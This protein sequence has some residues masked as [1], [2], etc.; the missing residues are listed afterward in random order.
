MAAFCSMSPF[1]V[2]AAADIEVLTPDVC[3]PGKVELRIINC[4]SCSTFEWQIGAGATFKAGTDNYATIITDTG[5]YDVTVKIKTTGGITFVIGKKRAFF[6]RMSP[7]PKLNISDSLICKLKDTVVFTDLTPGIVS[8]DWLI[9]GTVFYLAPKSIKYKFNGVQGFKSVYLLVRDSWGC[10]GTILKDSAVAIFD[11]T[12]VQITPSKSTGCAP[13]YVDFTTAFDTGFQKIKSVKWTFSGATPDSSKLRQPKGIYYPKGDTF[14]VQLQLRTQVGCKYNYKFNNVVSLGDTAILKISVPKTKF[15]VNE[16][17]FVTLSGSK[18]SN[19]NWNIGPA[20]N[21]IDTPAGAKI[22]V[23]FIDT[24]YAKIFVSENDRG[25]ISYTST[26]TNLQAQ[27]P[28]AYF[29][30][31]D[32]YYCNIPATLKYVNLS[33]A[34]PGGTSYKWTV[35]DSIWNVKSTGTNKDISYYTTV[36]A[37]YHVR[38]IASGTNGCSDTFTKDNASIFGVINTGFTVFPIPVCPNSKFQLK[39]VAGKGTT[40]KPNSFKWTFYDLNH[41]E[42]STSNKAE[43][44]Y[45]Y[46]KVGKYDAKLVIWNSNGCKDSLLLTDTITVQSPTPSVFI[47]DTF[48][49]KGEALAVYVKGKGKNKNLVAQW[50]IKNID[51]TADIVYGQADSFVFDLRKTGRWRVMYTLRDTA[52]NGCSTVIIHPSLIYVSG[53]IYTIGSDVKFGCSPL[54][55]QYSATNI[56]NVSYEKTGNSKFLWKKF[57]G[58]KFSF[59]DSSKQSPKALLPRG[60]QQVRLV[61][62]NA[63]GCSDS[64][65]YIS[66]NSGLDARFDISGFRCVGNTLQLYNGS[67]GW[68]TAVE[69]F[70]ND[71]NVVFVTSRFVNDPKIIFKTP[72]LHQVG[73]IAKYNSN[74]TDTWVLGIT[75]FQVKANFST[76]DSVS[77]C[78]PKLI[79]FQ[80]TTNSPYLNFWKFGD[81]DTAKTY[82]DNL[83]GHLYLKNNSSPGYDV[84]LI[85]IDG[86]G[87]TDTMRKKGYIRI[88]G[89]IPDFT[90]SQNYGCEPLKVKFTNNSKDFS[91]MFLDYDNGVV[92]DSNVLVSYPYQVTDKALAIQKFSPRLLLYDSF[93]CSAL[94]TTKDTVVILKNAEADYV[95]S[96]INFLR[97]TEGCANDLIVKFT[98]KSRFYV[99]TYW[100]FDNDNKNDLLNQ[101]SATWFFTKPGVFKPR[102]VAENVNGCRDTFSRD[103]IVVWDPPVAGWKSSSDTTC[104]INPM[105]FYDATSARYP[106]AS[107]NWNFGE[108]STIYDTSTLKNTKWKYSTPFYK[109]V[110]LKVI[111][112]NG[113]QDQIVKNI[114]VNDTAGPL[115]P[116][117]AFITVRNNQWVDF[118]WQKSKLGNYLTYHVMLDSLGFYKRYSTSLRSDTSYSVFYGS[119]PNNRRFCYTMQIEDT[120]HQMGRNAVSHC[121]MVLRDSAFEPFNIQ[122]NWLAYDWWDKDLSHYEVFRSVQGSN[123]FVKIADVKNTRQFYTD[124][125]LCDSVYCYYV[126]AVHRNRIWRSR[127]NEVC[128]RPIY[129]LPDK[130][131]NTTL[132][133]VQNNNNTEVFWEPYYKYYRNWSYELQRSSSGTPGSFSKL[134][135]TKALYYQ[136]YSANFNSKINYYRVI[137]RDHCHQEAAPGV[138]SNTILLQTNSQN[139]NS[140]SLIWNPYSYWYSGVRSYGVQLKNNNGSFNTIGMRGPNQNFMD[141]LNIES[142]SLDSIC[143]RV[144]AVKD[145][146]TNDTSWS[147]E[148]CL[149]PSSYVHVP[150]AFSPDQNG[151]NEVFKPVTGFIHRNSADPNERFEFQVYNRWGQLVFQTNEPSQ[152]WDGRFEGNIAPPG[153][154]VWT[155]KA[156]GYDGVP[157]HQTG[158]VLLVR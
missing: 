82:F 150:T 72:G 77:Y 151:L 103:S 25:C 109:G 104:A 120:C 78:A 135:E 98:N 41:K 67:S 69:Y 8:R 45:S 61:Y 105:F 21:K 81:G 33:A 119:E 157:H 102:L 19:P 13:V 37:R 140:T 141:S 26:T 111:D 148:V 20:K 130:W 86:N 74:C 47:P 36:G 100:D 71:P 49:C 1:L 46:P 121:T 39:S 22:K 96:S 87:C 52:P 60:Q 107:Y 112:S 93:G 4:S 44:E 79:N 114:F 128:K 144:F 89:P 137:F 12:K 143:F 11:S 149:V 34:W 30:S 85:V 125:F 132:A 118:Y 146:I 70:S 43:P 3:V 99:K 35:Y 101:N 50:N 147:N 48:V 110:Q 115:P 42:E 38:L 29:E 66:V 51:S 65:G 17:F 88:I 59:D 129:V 94:A 57:P 124:S 154:F 142:Y 27:G 7:V 53:V 156:L 76:P 55:V 40:A 54:N 84:Q 73:I 92:L 122:L 10:K 28:K 91:R 16:P 145:T 24:G 106:I 15:C 113:C 123:K 158:T 126:E 23:R 133:S 9:E 90:I 127:S 136:D 117:L 134:F 5:W 68:A 62:K 31:D 56:S 97:K 131:V 152:G 2:H 6:G 14:D 83:A 153:L 58:S 108:Q 18:S 75:A 116:S 138:I 64:T 139:R 95:Y 63:S 155:V 80:N 32:A